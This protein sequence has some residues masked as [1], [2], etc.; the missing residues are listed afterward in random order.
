[1]NRPSENVARPQTEWSARSRELGE[2]LARSGMGD[3]AAFA[4]LYEL[5]SGHLFAVV[6]RIQR[7]RTL[8]E[9]L[10]QEVYIAVWK[11]AGNFDAARSQ[12]LTW[13]THI[14]RNRA[15]D[16]LR[17]A[18]TQPQLQTSHLGSAESDD[19]G[20]VTDRVAADG[21][22]PLDLL[23]R[24]CDARELETCMERLSPPQ[25]QSVALAFFDGLSHA[26]VAE[27]LR[28]PLGTVKSWVRRA[29]QTLKTC[30]ERGALRDQAS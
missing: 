12:P 30:L 9:D 14:A 11:A 3:R 22:G 4:R 19:E 16:S 15:I 2:L 1:M 6:L 7:D 18:Q 27:H 20:D 28:E 17:R 25:R 23:D 8:A 21:P 5:S 13:L 26:E 29:L 10:L 24:A